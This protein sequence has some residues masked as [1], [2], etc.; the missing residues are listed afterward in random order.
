MELVLSIDLGTS[1]FK[2][3]LFDRAGKMR[4]LRRVAVPADERAPMRCEL[5]V[6]R[7]FAMLEDGLS[8]ACRQAG[9]TTQDIAAVAYSSQA[10]SFV[11]LDDRSHPLTPL[12]LWPDRR[13]A[14]EVDPRV[15]ALWA[16]EDFL[17]TTGLGMHSDGMALAKWLWFQRH[18]P[19]LWSQMRR[20]MTIS[21]FL[22]FTL[23]GD[24]AGD[25]GTASLLGLW[26]LERHDW[27]DEAIRAAGLSR[28]QLSRPLLPG[29]VAGVVSAQAAERFGLRARIPVAVGSLDHHVAA[30]GAGIGTVAPV[31]EST[32]TVLA[33]LGYSAEYRPRR[34]CCMGPN[35]AGGWYQLAFDSNGAAGLEWCLR[36][37]GQPAGEASG[38]GRGGCAIQSQAPADGGS[39]ARPG[40]H[41][42]HPVHDVHHVH[43]VH[44]VH[45]IEEL[46]HLAESAGP[47]AGGLFARPMAWTF[48]GLSGFVG[49][50]NSHG[51]GHFTRAMMESTAATLLDLVD[52][53]RPEGRPDRIVATGGGARSDLWLQIKAD[54][55]GSVFV[56][57]DCEE[58]ASRGA[59]MI[60]AVAAGWFASADEAGAAWIAVR[61]RFVP[62]S[63]GRAFYR[64][65]HRE[66]NRRVKGTAQGA[67]FQAKPR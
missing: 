58:P 15:S 26:A 30:I 11:L 21:D 32:G 23:T 64:K 55:I 31:S 8:Q 42:G 10:N 28:E 66:Q 45:S 9:A 34:H 24:T 51:H 43:S 14:G 39:G 67:A 16:R 33:C 46:V 20:V 29:T 35:G 36:R 5:P 27:W 54:L 3:G 57:T 63:G 1:Y 56:A 62:E 18:E 53:L 41:D 40:A 13:A 6:E 60:A 38:A 2:L 25:E 44:N 17:R 47:G 49:R 7:F 52:Q 48:D 61:N 50:T 37:A 22:V 19:A 65:W 59:A 12:V 4:G